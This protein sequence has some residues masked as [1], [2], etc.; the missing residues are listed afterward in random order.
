MPRPR[1]RR[2]RPPDA[3]LPD[4]TPLEPVDE[5]TTRVEPVGTVRLVPPPA[6]DTTRGGA[7]VGKLATGEPAPVVHPRQS[8][9]DDAR[10]AKRRAERE[11]R[12]VRQDLERATAATQRAGR[13]AVAAEERVEKLRRELMSAEER[14]Q[15]ANKVV[16]ALAADAA[17]IALELK[18]V[19]ETLDAARRR[20]RELES[21]HPTPPGEQP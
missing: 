9:I 8:S 20:V 12:Q 17:E 18:R 6:P 5:R 21:P 4:I 15:E 13:R 10:L 1:P 19:Y 14:A 3:T 11:Y 16:D 7:P 2:R